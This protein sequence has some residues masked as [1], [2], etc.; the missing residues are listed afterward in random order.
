VQVMMLF[1]QLGALSRK[2]QI[3]PFDREA[4]GTIL[5]EGIGMLVLKRLEDARRDG[6]RVYAVIKGVGTASDGRGL[7]VMAP[8]VEGEVLALE[9]A[10]KNAAIDPR[11]VGLI[12]AHGTGTPVGDAAEVTALGRVFGTRNGGGPSC[13]LGSVKSM[14]GHTMGAASAIEA[15]VCAL[16]VFND[17]VP[18]T[19]NL[20]EPD[21]ECDL[22][23][24][25][26]FARELRVNVA[27]NNA[28]AF[29]GNNASLILRK[30]S[31]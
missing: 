2:E 15:A 4:D 12:E 18:P 23:Y 7:S 13:A 24:V 19:I 10:Y 20:N 26:N 28:Y 14:L 17:R 3:R 6:N 31:Y 30:R 5:G 1:C 25:P 8:R 11:T 27:M 29:G 22:D 16:A 21:P 9:R